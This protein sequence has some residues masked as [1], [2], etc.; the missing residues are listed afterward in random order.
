MRFSIKKTLLYLIIFSSIVSFTNYGKVSVSD[1]ITEK[2]QNY[3]ESDWP[4]KVYV[5]TDKPYYSVGDDIWFSGYLVNGITHSKST[6]SWVVHVELIDANDSIVSSRKL[7]TDNIGFSGDFKIAEDWREGAYLLRAYT[8]YMR[9]GSPEYFFQ[10]ELPIFHLEENNGSEVFGETK[11]AAIDYTVEKP[12]L[13][14]YPEGGHLVENLRNKVAIKIKNDIYSS[15]NLSCYIT[16]EEQTVVSQFSTTDFGMGYFTFIPEPNKSYVAN[17]EVNGTEFNYPLPKALSKGYVMNVTNSD[18]HFIVDV[19]S[20]MPSGLEGTSLVAHQRG[21]MLFNNHE[22][23]S[24]GNY[25]LKFSTEELKDGVVTLTLFDADGHP[26]CERLIFVDNPKNNGKIEIKS[27]KKTVQKR[28]KITLDIFTKDYEG[29]KLPSQLSMSVRDMSAF[30]LNNKQ[31]NI[32]TWL[33][34]NSDLRGEIKNPGYFFRDG[35][36][37]RT[38]FLLD[39]VMMTHG[40]RR[41]TWQELLIQDDTENKYAIETGLT[42][43]GTTKQ[44]KSP[45]EPIS[46]STRLTLF[47]DPFYQAPVQASGKDGKFSFG[48][49]VFFDS[50][51]VMVESRLTDFK[52]KELKDRNVDISIA[53]DIYQRPPVDKRMVIK[54]PVVDDDKLNNYLYLANYIKQIDMD[55]DKEAVR[56]NS[57]TVVGNKKE[58]FQERIEEMNNRTLHK[59]FYSNRLDVETRKLD[60]YGFASS[61]TIQDLVNT[62]VPGGNRFSSLSNN[63]V[64]PIYLLN[65]MKTSGE[66][67]NALPLEMVSFI[68]V[69]KPPDGLMYTSQNAWVIAIYTREGAR[70]FDE[71]RKPGIIDFKAEGFYTAREFYAPD[72]SNSFDVRKKADVRTTLHWQPNITTTLDEPIKEISFY[73][74]DRV[75]DYIVEIEGMSDSGIP[76]H[77]ITTFSVQ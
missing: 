28:E 30:P 16:D 53:N 57:V 31:E 48:P 20:N 14:F 72:Y 51:P 77:E 45:Q 37:Y 44:L 56:L 24:K 26:V 10:K 69:I 40:W 70:V 5:H 42:I 41:F 29:K 23:T 47:G 7:F 54:D 35:A 50:I 19:K 64:S 36:D 8:N 62:M 52:S 63:D 3:A 49:Y 2:L 21:H 13:Q 38:K 67:I 22:T 17:I 75:G 58:K 66:T 73:A 65:N 18:E 27:S 68:D 43:S 33:L 11:E 12:D 32:K 76:L 61:Q 6:K 46:A 4:E 1:L 55:F 15:I 39:L 25:P 59:G 71:K 9:N 74:S 60:E 34:L